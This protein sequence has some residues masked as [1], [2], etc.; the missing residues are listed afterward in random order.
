[1]NIKISRKKM[2]KLAYKHVEEYYQIPDFYTYSGDTKWFQR[3]YAAIAAKNVV[4]KIV[5]LKDTSDLFD[6]L[7]DLAIE[8]T[9]AACNATS[10]EAN[11]MFSVAA[12]VVMDFIDLYIFL[13]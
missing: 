9:D 12:D 13:K 8:Y 11:F 1:M 10:S 5:R 4:D 7:N 6:I 2:I 3:C